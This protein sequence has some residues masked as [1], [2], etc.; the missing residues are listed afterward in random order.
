MPSTC[1]VSGSEE[2]VGETSRGWSSSNS[3][4]GGQVSGAQQTELWELEGIRC[5]AQE[6]GQQEGPQG[7]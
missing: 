2:E 4:G 3:V 6:R 7:S 1:S 5:E